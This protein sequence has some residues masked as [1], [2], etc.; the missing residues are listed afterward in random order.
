M[1]KM[2]W[3]LLHPYTFMFFVKFHIALEMCGL[4]GASV[5]CCARPTVLSAMKKPVHNG[6]FCIMNYVGNS[7]YCD[8][9]L[10]VSARDQI[11]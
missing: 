11:T 8:F 2:Q 3:R 4:F 7:F 9:F 1:Q 6:R 10:Y 5:Y